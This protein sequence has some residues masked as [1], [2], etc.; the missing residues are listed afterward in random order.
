MRNALHEQLLKAGLIDEKRLEESEREKKRRDQPAQVHGRQGGQPR[1]GKS[2]ARHPHGHGAGQPQ[3][4]HQGPR[5]SPGEPRNRPQ[6]SAPQPRREASAASEAAGKAAGKATAQA[7]RRALEREIVQLIKANRHPH[8]DGDE[9]FNF[10]DGRKVGRIYCTAETQ[11]RLTAGELAIV[12][13]RTRYAVVPTA[14]AA[15]IAAKAREFVLVANPQA[16]SAETLDPAY[17]EHPIPD[18]LRW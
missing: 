10:V 11:K 6:A 17:A 2:R 8:N 5:Q 13:L 4:A 12:R 7:E 18:D 15:G 9:V 1:D 3:R 14:T 16:D